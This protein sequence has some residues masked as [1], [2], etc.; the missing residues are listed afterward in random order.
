MRLLLLALPLA[1]VLAA[2][3]IRIL[4]VDAS[5]TPVRA[6]VEV[7]GPDGKMYQPG[8][9]VSERAK[10]IRFG[11]DHPS[12][13]SFL[14]DGECRV[15]VPPGRY[16][17][18]VERGLEY[19]RL[20]RSMDAPA[21]IT[22]TNRRWIDMDK[23][24]WWSGDLH[25]HRASDELIPMILT[26]DVNLGANFT[27]WNKRSWWRDKPV[28]ADP[29]VRADDRHITTLLNAEDERG[30]G[31]WCINGLREPID[32]AVDG[33]WYP[34][35][36]KFVEQ[37]RAQR[38]PGDLLPWFDCEKPI[39]WE[40]PVMM[41]L[42]TPDS[43]G[44]AHNHFTQYGMLDNEVWGR[45]RDQR[46]FPG[47]RGFVEYCLS[48]Y[49]RYLNLGFKLAPSAGSATGVLP[50]P[51]GYNRVYVRRNG[52]ELT[53]ANWYR[54]LRDGPSIATNG[55][56]LFFEVKGQGNRRTVEV[57]ARSVVPIRVVEVVA[58][59]R[60]VHSEKPAGNGRNLRF[61]FRLDAA[62]HSWVAARCFVDAERTIRMAHTSPVYLDGRFDA[63]EDAR[64]FLTWVE[65]LISQ[66]RADAKRFQSDAERDEVLVLYERAKTFYARRAQ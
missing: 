47:R 64:Y 10:R 35:G 32:V 57:D 24:G 56:V 53:A 17:V 21:T 25:V 12:V 59:G 40:T 29:V 45:P 51:M 48:L 60:V 11:E 1:A 58:N 49:Y 30:G 44:V 23:L 22:F 37:A 28:P 4:A 20:E 15:E 62:K 7:R 27:V 61:R 5:G 8:G 9:I 65:E 34:A 41:A 43:L 33:R 39:W 19:E 55:P 14:M 3:E 52:Q 18:V 38:R 63:R 16:L 6:R 31:A 46:Q 2:A 13:G 26:E 66:T 54:A 36:I 42:A 50:N